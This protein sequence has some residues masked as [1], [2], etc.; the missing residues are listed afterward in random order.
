MMITP[1]HAR[2]RRANRWFSQEA[3]AMPNSDQQITERASD[4]ARRPR[5]RSPKRTDQAHERVREDDCGESSAAFLFSR[6][7]TRDDLPLNDAMVRETVYDALRAHPDF[8]AYD[9]D[10]YVANGEVTLL[11]KVDSVSGERL[12]LETAERCHGV[13]SVQCQFRF[14][15]RPIVDTYEGP[16]RPTRADADGGRHGDDSRAY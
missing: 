13:Q 6:R 10:V 14:G 15:H 5:Q 16:A 3:R 1:D 11:G 12:A 8:D 2:M 4:A 7:L 9:I